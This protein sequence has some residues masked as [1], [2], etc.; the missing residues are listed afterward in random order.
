MIQV[1]EDKRREAEKNLSKFRCHKFLHLT[2]GEQRRMDGEDER[3]ERR[4]QRAPSLTLLLLFI[5]KSR[6]SVRGS[7]HS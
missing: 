4:P 7:A 6:H 2:H 1:E 5:Q 3:E